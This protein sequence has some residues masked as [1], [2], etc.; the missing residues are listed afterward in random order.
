MRLAVILLLFAHNALAGPLIDYH[1]ATILNILIYEKAARTPLKTKEVIKAINNCND[2]E[3][4]ASFYKID[5]NVFVRD[6]KAF[7]D[8]TDS[9]YYIARAD[10][11]LFLDLD[12]DQ[13]KEILFHTYFNYQPLTVI[14]KQKGTGYEMIFRE[15]AY[16]TG[17]TFTGRQL[18]N[19]TICNPHNDSSPFD[20]FRVYELVLNNN[21]TTIKP[22]YSLNVPYNYH[23]PV[24]V[25]RVDDAIDFNVPVLFYYYNELFSPL[26]YP[27][28]SSMKDEF[29]ANVNFNYALGEWPDLET[30]NIKKAVYVENRGGFSS[31]MVCENGS[32]A[33]EVPEY[34]FL[35]IPNKLLISE[36]LR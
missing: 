3:V 32:F 33:T 26:D 18:K 29:N 7:M 1:R 12:N 27:Y 2:K 23:Y 30:K 19:F 36:L 13:V 14:F 20:F 8:L 5:Y 25:N 9:S 6:E 28:N 10:Q 4:Q 11:C 15:H 35:Y 21:V 34:I 22:I 17:L 31:V 24:K 16:V